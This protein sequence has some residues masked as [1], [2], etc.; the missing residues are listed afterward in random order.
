M[1]RERPILAHVAIFE[2]GK[3]ANRQAIGK[4][5]EAS[6]QRS[7]VVRTGPSLHKTEASRA[8][9]SLLA[10]QALDIDTRPRKI[11][12]LFTSETTMH[13]SAI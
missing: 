3:V 2:T 11:A 8:V 9:A 10:L 13:A 5:L 6:T 7:P 1:A 12:T 4:V